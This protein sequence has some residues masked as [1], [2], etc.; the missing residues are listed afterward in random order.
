MLVL[1]VGVVAFVLLRDLTRTDPADPVRPVDYQETLDFAQQAVGFPL[2]APG[3]LPEGWRA[4]S[5]TFVPD[6]ARWHL[7]VL[8]DEDRYVGIEQARSSAAEMVE[9]YVDPDARRGETVTVAGDRWQVWTD[10][11]GDTAL[12]RVEQGV[13]TLVVGTP[14]LSV[15]REY[16]NSLEEAGS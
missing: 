3:R 12:T 8:T 11:G 9:S 14:E 15:L 7:G 6:P 13:T 4:T 16:A 10:E 1:V 2:L 5:A